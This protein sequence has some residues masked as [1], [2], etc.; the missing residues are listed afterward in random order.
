MTRIRSSAYSASRVCP[1]VESTAKWISGQPLD[2]E[3]AQGFA[4]W[5]ALESA[6]Q[7]WCFACDCSSAINV[8]KEGCHVKKMLTS[9]DLRRGVRFVHCFQ[10]DTRR[11]HHC[12]VRLPEQR[13]RGA[14][15]T[16]QSSAVSLYSCIWDCCATETAEPLQKQP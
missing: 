6:W 7:F 8:R 3:N 14:K 4:L 12:A 1:Q 5:L 13:A 11:L 10:T 15:D 9:L 16:A 2:L